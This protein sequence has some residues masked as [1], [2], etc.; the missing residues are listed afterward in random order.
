MYFPEPSKSVLIVRPE[1]LK[2]G[3]VFRDR[4]I[5]K[6]CT[7]AHYLGG[8]IGYDDSKH[9]WLRERT[10]TWDKNINTISKIAGKCPQDSYPT[11][12]NV[13]Q[14]EWI[15]LQC[16]TWYTGRCVFWGVENVQGNLF[17]SSFIWKEKILSPII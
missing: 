5:F 9:N 14:A 2:A 16:V 10:L 8:Y 7:G 1:N 6:V 12:V 11:V 4:H 3:K 13:I 15:F 17:A